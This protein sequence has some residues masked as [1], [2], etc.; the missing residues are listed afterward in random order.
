ML[1]ICGCC[2]SCGRGEGMR[3]FWCVFLFGLK[4]MGMFP[5]KKRGFQVPRA[6]KITTND[7]FFPGNSL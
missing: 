6:V 2:N 4:T 5:K 7:I 3:G 1:E